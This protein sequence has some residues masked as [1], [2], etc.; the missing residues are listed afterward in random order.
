MRSHVRNKVA[1]CVFRKHVFQTKN[2]IYFYWKIDVFENKIFTFLARD[3]GGVLSAAFSAPCAPSVT[4]TRNRIRIDLGAQP[5]APSVT[6]TRN[7]IRIDLGALPCVPSVTPTRNRIRMDLPVP[8]FTPARNRIRMDLRAG[9]SPLGLGPD[10]F[11]DPKP[12][13]AAPNS[14]IFQLYRWR[15]SGHS[16]CAGGGTQA[17]ILKTR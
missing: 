17:A 16:D 9:I 14:P 15:V 11:W 3:V 8:S 7:R 10:R 2:G 1:S 12:R 6:P 5:C 4:P 13:T